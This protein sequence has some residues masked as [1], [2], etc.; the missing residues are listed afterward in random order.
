MR[1][2]IKNIIFLLFLISFFIGFWQVCKAQVG[3]ELLVDYPPIEGEQPYF[4][5][6]LPELIRYIYM[7]ALGAVGIVALIAILIGAVM[8]VTSAGNPDKMRDAKDRIISAI[9][10]IILLL[11]SVLILR[12]INPDLVRLGFYLEPITSIPYEDP[13][14]VETICDD[15]IDNDVDG[16]VDMSDPDCAGERI[17]DD[18]VDNDGDEAVDC[19]DTDCASSPDCAG[20]IACWCIILATGEEFWPSEEG[21]CH[22]DESDCNSVCPGLCTQYYNQCVSECEIDF[23]GDD[24]AIEECILLN[25]PTSQICQLDALCP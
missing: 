2:F 7:F 22:E 19:A 13:G 15:E 14:L 18:L 6:E 5:M 4:G 9:L 12:L 3:Q 11:S 25:C 24:P 1:K 23:F 20:K 17:C 10:G 16:W 8:Y 21:S